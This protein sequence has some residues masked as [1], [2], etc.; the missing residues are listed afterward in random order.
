M[1]SE[2]QATKISK[3]SKTE[4]DGFVLYAI[5]VVFLWNAISSCSED[6]LK[7][8]LQVCDSITDKKLLSL[9]CL[10]EGAS[11]NQLGNKDM[12]K[13]VREYS[14]FLFAYAPPSKR[15]WTM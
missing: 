15:K 8:I 7:K 5:E 6:I 13:Q 10:I 12:A 3:D 1:R 9:K 14:L 11:Y 4:A 2:F